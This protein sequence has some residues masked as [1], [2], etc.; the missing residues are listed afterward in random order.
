MNAAERV[1]NG[2]FELGFYPFGDVNGSGS[3]GNYWTHLGQSTP[4][5]GV[6]SPTAPRA[7]SRKLLRAAGAAQGSIRTSRYR[8]ARSAWCRRPFWS[9]T[10]AA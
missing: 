8:R 3:I 2:A 7:T 5:Q 10:T 1:T 6:F 9:P 4:P